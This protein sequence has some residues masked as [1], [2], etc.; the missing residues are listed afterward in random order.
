MFDGSREKYYP[1]DTRALFMIMKPNYNEDGWPE[2]PNGYP[3]TSSHG[4]NPE[5]R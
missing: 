2:D 1:P 3:D 4:E 5:K